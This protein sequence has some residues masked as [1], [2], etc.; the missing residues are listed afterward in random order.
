MVLGQ[1]EGRGRAESIC[2]K[3][4]QG[5]WDCTHSYPDHLRYAFNCEDTTVHATEMSLVY[6]SFNVIHH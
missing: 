2:T 6:F 4:E 5:S 1:S 3:S